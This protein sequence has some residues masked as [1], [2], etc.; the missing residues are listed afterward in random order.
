MS[1]SRSSTCSS[2]GSDQVMAHRERFG[3]TSWTVLEP[4]M[5]AFAPVAARVREREAAP[6]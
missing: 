2:S 1:G 3:F 5:E 4:Y 6:A